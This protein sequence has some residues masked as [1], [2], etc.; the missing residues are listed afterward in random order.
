MSKQRD[1]CPPQRTTEKGKAGALLKKKI[2]GVAAI[3][4]TKLFSELN[5]AAGPPSES[6]AGAGGAGEAES[7]EKP[8]G[9]GYI[10]ENVVSP[11]LVKF[12]NT[13]SCLIT[14]PPAHGFFPY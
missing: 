6:K 9:A 3:V 12:T 13:F 7:K 14:P 10:F 4:K 8:G 11:I 5:G 2:T 1:R